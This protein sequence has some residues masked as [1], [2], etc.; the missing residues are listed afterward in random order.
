MTH[1][2]AM[3]PNG[4]GIWGTDPET[5]ELADFSKWDHV[6]Y[7][8]EITRDDGSVAYRT[9]LYSPLPDR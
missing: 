8:F 5:P 3:T 4:Y 6:P 1:R 7:M 9:D 2:L